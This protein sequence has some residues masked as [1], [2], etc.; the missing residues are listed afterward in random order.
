MAGARC[1]YAIGDEVLINGL[2]T[3]KDSINSYTVDR[4]TEGIAVKA[5]ENSK[6]FNAQVDKIITTREIYADKLRE[7]LKSQTYSH[8]IAAGCG[9]QI[10]QPLE[11]DSRQLVDDD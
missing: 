3:V 5:L 2:K 10:I 7:I 9:N 6:Y 11:I 8:L 1:G 4:L